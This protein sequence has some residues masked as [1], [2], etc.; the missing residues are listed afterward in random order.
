M[1][2]FRRP[3]RGKFRAVPRLL[4]A[5]FGIIF[6]EYPAERAVPRVLMLFRACSA[7]PQSSCVPRGAEFTRGYVRSM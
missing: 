6:T 7:V 1:A 5:P 4:R 3:F 2:L